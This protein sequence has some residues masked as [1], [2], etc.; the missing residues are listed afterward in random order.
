MNS[1]CRREKKEARSATPPREKEKNAPKTHDVCAP[2]SLLEL[3]LRDLLERDD[4][5][6]Q[7]VETDGS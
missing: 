2:A 5:A 4:G 7:D 3:G 6:K 1:S